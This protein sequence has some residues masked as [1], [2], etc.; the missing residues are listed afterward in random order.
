MTVN[1]DAPA[2]IVDGTLTDGEAWVALATATPDGANVTFTST[3]GANDWSQYQ[4]LVILIYA[5]TAGSGTWRDIMMNFNNDTGSNYSNQ[6]MYGSGSSAAAQIANPAYSAI[7][8]MPGSSATANVFGA[9]V[10]NIFDINSGKYTCATTEGA[11]M[12]GNPDIIWHATGFW[13][14]QAPVTEIDLTTASGFAAGS[15]F[16]LFGVLPRMVS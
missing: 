16:D 12:G 6:D 5:R 9:A 3:T 10:Y 2:Y 13:E 7:V 14:S 8:F 4:D 11:A 15:R 1:T